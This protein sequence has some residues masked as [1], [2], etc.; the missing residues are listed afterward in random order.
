LNT[1]KR[2]EAFGTNFE[3]FRT[4]LE[5]FEASTSLQLNYGAFG[6]T[7]KQLGSF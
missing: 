5:A 7:L 6:R 1:L 4:N 3:A 2:N